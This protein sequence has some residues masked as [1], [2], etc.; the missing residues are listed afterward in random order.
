MF[1]TAELVTPAPAGV[2]VPASAVFLK[3]D[4]HYV[5]VEQGRGSFK[6]REVKVGSE[7]DGQLLVVAA[8]APGENVVSE[9]GI[10]LDQ[11]ISEATPH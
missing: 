2:E 9:G 7:R 10:V 8:L 6:R 1:V 3:G 4:Q 5:F 11:I